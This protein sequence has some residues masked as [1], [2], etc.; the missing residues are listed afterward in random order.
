MKFNYPESFYLFSTD[1]KILSFFKN[2][3]GVLDLSS[4]RG[5]PREMVLD[6]LCKDGET[7]REAALEDP[8]WLKV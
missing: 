6:D 1:Y 4:C 2:L 3:Q 8:C 7:P 5:V